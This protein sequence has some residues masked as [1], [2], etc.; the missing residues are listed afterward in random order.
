[1]QVLQG[2]QTNP[3]TANAAVVLGAGDS[4]LHNSA[5]QV[6][7]YDSDE[8]KIAKAITADFVSDEE[9]AIRKPVYAYVMG[10]ALLVLTR[11]PQASQ[12]KDAIKQGVQ[13]M[14]RWYARERRK[15]VK[16]P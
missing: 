8:A 9:W 1:L 14:L 2:I 4:I 5:I 12:E 13:A 16:G 11:D 3:S 6:L 10:A 7:D 15:L